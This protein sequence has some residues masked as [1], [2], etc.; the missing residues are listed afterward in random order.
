MIISLTSIKLKGPFS[1][2]L[3][4]LRAMRVGQ[5]LQTTPCKAFRKRGIWT[6]HYTMT[7]WNSEQ[8]MADFVRSPAHREAMKG[9]ASLAM[10]IRLHTYEG[11]WLPDW[12][13]AIGLLEQGKV[14]RY[15]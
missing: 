8:E 1:F 13:E 11:T 5:Q 9:S 4:S 6:T 7:L 2:F 14:L 3:F 15:G 10:E 12:P